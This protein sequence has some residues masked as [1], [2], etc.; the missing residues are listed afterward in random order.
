MTTPDKRTDTA[1]LWS[2]LLIVV[3]LACGVGAIAG[4]LFGFGRLWRLAPI[5]CGAIVV[6]AVVGLVARRLSALDERAGAAQLDAPPPARLDAPPPAVAREAERRPSPARD[7]E[8]LR[9]MRYGYLRSANAAFRLTP[10]E[11]AELLTLAPGGEHAALRRSYEA[12]AQCYVRASDPPPR[13]PIAPPIAPPVTLPVTLP[14]PPIAPPVT[15]P[16]APITLQPAPVAP[17]PAPVAPQ[18][19]PVAPPVKRRRD[20]RLVPLPGPPSWTFAPPTAPRPVPQ[21]D[22]ADT[23]FA[24]RRL[25]HA[26]LTRYVDDR[27]TRQYGAGWV[28]RLENTWRGPGTPPDATA[29]DLAG[30]RRL[31]IAEWGAVFAHDVAFKRRGARDDIYALRDIRNA[32]SHEVVIP[33]A[34]AERAVATMER[35]L[36]DTGAP[37]AR[38][39]ARLKDRIRADA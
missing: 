28:R 30:V 5:A 38:D 2:G 6:A 16:P 14:P 3:A 13:A 27:L 34:E 20:P 11:F 35:L 7:A 12:N 9:A 21:V 37:E 25:L 24:A 33:P 19:A 31:L 10:A 4:E 18:P 36:R 29:P 15:L 23:V 17:Q 32:T 8:P 39:I 26:G 22:M 1:M